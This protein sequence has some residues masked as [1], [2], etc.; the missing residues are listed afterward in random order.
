MLLSLAICVTLA[1]PVVA[2]T[3]LAT[4]P[5]IT[6]DPW[7]D[8][9]LT[10]AGF[11]TWGALHL[12]QPDL[13]DTPCP[14]TPGQVNAFDRVAVG[15]HSTF[16]EPVAN[17]FAISALGVSLLAPVVANEGESWAEDSLLILQSI[18]LAGTL[19]ELSKIAVGRPYPYMHGPAPYPEQNGDG[20]NYASF[21][22]G[23][24]ATPMAAA[25]TAARLISMRDPDSP[26]RWVAWI[27]GPSLALGSGVAQIVASNHYP[28][29]VIAGAGVGV[30]VGL[31]I[32]WLHSD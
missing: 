5:R 22:S 4:P 29:D 16:A 15:G 9:P 27:V 10:A 28:T 11:G 18:A 7:I 19:T 3:P 2:P 8:A 26:W 20:V 21:W 17:A 25:V 6:V 23:H 32:P 12:A 30:G 14:C 24:T 13:V 1:A 31:L